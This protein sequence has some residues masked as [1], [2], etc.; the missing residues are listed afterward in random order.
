MRYELRLTAYDMLDRV[1]V[2]VVV[3]EASD[4]PQVSTQVV[5]RSTTVQPGTGEQ[6][7]L[8]WTR[9]ALVQALEAL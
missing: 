4:I 3:L 7:P 2:A 6:D 1:A 9:D 8:Q 5:H